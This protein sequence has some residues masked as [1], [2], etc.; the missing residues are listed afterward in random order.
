MENIPLQKKWILAPLS[1]NDLIEQL[2]LNRKI[3]KKNWNNFLDPQ[4]SRDLHDP[5]LLNDMAAVVDLLIKAIKNKDTIGIFGD[6]DADGIPASALLAEAL[7]KC[8][9][10]P[11]VYIPSREEGYGLNKKGVDEL[12]N[13]GAKVL[14]TVDLGIRALKE[15]AYAKS[16]GLDVIITDH[17]EP[18]DELPAALILNPKL[19]QSQYPFRELSGGGVVY[20]L[21]Q[22]LSQKVNLISDND[23]K[24]MLD[25]VAITTICDVVPLTDENR[26][27]AKYGLVVLQKTKRIGL[28]KLYEVSGIDENN[29]STYTV[30]FQIGPRLNAPGRMNKKQESFELLTTDNS[31]RALELARELD[32][33]NKKRQDEFDQILAEARSQVISE[34]LNKK[35]VICLSNKNW[36]SGLIG[37]VAGRLVE[38]FARPC[39]I[40]EQGDKKSKGSARSIDNYNIVEVLEEAKDLIENFGGHAKAAGLTIENS[41]LQLLYDKLLSIADSK[42]TDDDLVPTIKIDAYV[43]T[44]DLTLDL[45]DKIKVLEPFGLGNPKPVFALKNIKADS[46]RLIGQTEKHLKFKIGPIDVI[47]FNM[48]ELMPKIIDQNISLAFNLDENIWNNTRKIQL[49]I[50]DIKL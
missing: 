10:K 3:D 19:Q 29:I 21:I 41:R 24:W 7:K 23:L 43:E 34:K 48:A 13:S 37:L 39:L 45:Y 11:I 35:K 16:I 40:F 8:G 14:I 28:K 20:K 44:S 12:K 18:G 31:E 4:F 17:H 46:V 6:Y 33:V 2:L 30:G 47:A 9:L 27:F 26:I 42:L 1:G 36:S 25:L 5:F 15:I 50:I 32:E 49:K 38:E 22:A